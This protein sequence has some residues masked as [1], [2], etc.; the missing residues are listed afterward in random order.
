MDRPSPQTYEQIIGQPAAVNR[1]KAAL[2]GGRVAHALLLCGPDG[3]GKRTL[4]QILARA[5]LCTSDEK[6]CNHCSSCKKALSGNHA[7]LHVLIPREEGAKGGPERTLAPG[8]PRLK[9]KSLGVEEARAIARL[10]DVKPYE[11]GRAIV[12]IDSAQEL[13]IAAQNT[14]LKTLEEPPEHVVFLLLAESL[15]ALLPTVL[16]RC[17]VVKLNRLSAADTR[18]VLLDRGCPDDTRT[19]EAVN[20]SD[21]LPGRALELLPDDGFWT[22][23]DQALQ[24]LPGLVGSG[25]LAEAMRFMQDN[26]NRWPLLIDIWERAIR[27]AL[28]DHAGVHVPYMLGTAQPSLRAL[29]PQRLESMLVAIQN[30]RRAMDGNGIFTVVMDNL[31]IEFTGG[32]TA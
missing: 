17:A 14:M 19:A 16:S 6:P 27:D 5:L 11:G 24:A 32:I 21:G 18:R 4:A 9:R 10:I 23:R 28:M 8:T 2:T 26:R 20:L 25:R 29:P 15:S 1:L 3:S 30:A 31:L 12:V 22:L 7:D 13:T